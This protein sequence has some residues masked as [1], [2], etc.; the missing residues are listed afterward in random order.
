MN[1]RIITPLIAVIVGCEQNPCGDLDAESCMLAADAMDGPAGPM[2][3]AACEAGSQQACVLVSTMFILGCKGDET[4]I[5]LA[6]ATAA[7]AYQGGWEHGATFIA[8]MYEAKPTPEWSRSANWH[9]RACTDGY[10][11]SC[12]PALR[13]RLE[14]SATPDE[15]AVARLAAEMQ[16]ATDLPLSLVD[17][18]RGHETTRMQ[19]FEGVNQFPDLPLAPV[20]E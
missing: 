19:F 7:V 20:A 18:T 8:T 15:A 3:L 9:S 2:M 11:P 12:A 4:R 5:H 6:T 16:V 17:G 13:S 1:I 10:L 14:A